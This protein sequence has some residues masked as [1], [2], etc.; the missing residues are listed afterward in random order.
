MAYKTVTKLDDYINKYKEQ[1]SREQ[2]RDITISE[3]MEEIANHAD[4]SW[5][6][7][8]QMK[9][10]VIQPSLAVALRIADFF[11]VKAE[12][13][14]TVVQYENEL[15]QKEKEKTTEKKK[16]KE[17]AK[18]KNPN[19]ENDAIARG[20]CN[21]HYQT[22]RNHNMDKFNVERAKECSVE[23]CNNPYHAKGMCSFHYNKHYRESRKANG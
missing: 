7:I 15:I 16:K 4:I 8:K 10:N 14:W 2:N 19:C 13:I 20:F 17:K 12:D 1:V 23:G 11:N 6:T 3:V 9:Y 5:N 18:C 22:Y 21:T